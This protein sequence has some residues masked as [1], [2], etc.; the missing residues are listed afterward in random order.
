MAKVG[1]LVTPTGRLVL[2][3]DGLG[4]DEGLLKRDPQRMEYTDLAL[5]PVADDEME[6]RQMFQ[7]GAAAAYVD[8]R[9]RKLEQIIS[10]A[11]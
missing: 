5:E 11:A 8:Q 4:R 9:Q 7:T 3:P 6:T 10:K 2:G 1:E